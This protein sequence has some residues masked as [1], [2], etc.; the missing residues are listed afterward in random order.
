[1]IY[2]A[3]LQKNN[4]ICKIKKK[5][6]FL[7]NWF[8]GDLQ[9]A[10]R[11]RA[12]LHRLVLNPMQQRTCEGGKVK[13][14]FFIVKILYIL[15]YPHTSWLGVSFVFAHPPPPPPRLRVQR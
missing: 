12:L 10:P 5:L 15:N 13:F 8:A 14:F 3:I 7:N 4:D 9:L 2:C 6:H 11:K 1:M